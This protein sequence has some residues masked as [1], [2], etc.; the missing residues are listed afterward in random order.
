MLLAQ[1]SG[2]MRFELVFFLLAILA[3]S[4]G[5]KKYCDNAYNEMRDKTCTFAQQSMP[6]LSPQDPSSNFNLLLV[7]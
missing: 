1:L 7:N 4:A 6:C 2:K 5:A 3:I